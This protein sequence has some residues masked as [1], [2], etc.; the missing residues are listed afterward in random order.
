MT[1]TTSM[2]VFLEEW[3]IHW[4]DFTVE[5]MGNGLNKNKFPVTI[6]FLRLRYIE[7]IEN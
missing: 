5:W 7:V 2:S 4:W 6:R 1:A 3:D